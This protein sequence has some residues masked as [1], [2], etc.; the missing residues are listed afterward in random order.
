MINKGTCLRLP[1]IAHGHRIGSL[2]WFDF[3]RSE[4]S[5]VK[6]KYPPLCLRNAFCNKAAS[7]HID[8]GHRLPTL[9][10]TSASGRASSTHD[11]I[12]APLCP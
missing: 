6:G 11:A 9:H 7:A 5:G 12:Q 2:S 1:F 4:S 10:Q 8:H 3:N